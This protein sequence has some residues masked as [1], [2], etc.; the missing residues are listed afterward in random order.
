MIFRELFKAK[1]K[2]PFC[3]ATGRRWLTPYRSKM[4]GRRHIRL[5]HS[6]RDTDPILEC[7]K[8]ENQRKL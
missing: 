3:D 1:W 5:Y 4:H 2:C 6:V 7:R 8:T